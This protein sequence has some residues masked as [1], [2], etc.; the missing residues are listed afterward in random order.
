MASCPGRPSAG[1]QG[2]TITPSLEYIF[3][4]L[5]YV[6][7]IDLHTHRMSCMAPF[8][9][10]SQLTFQRSCTISHS[11][12]TVAGAPQCLLVLVNTYYGLFCCN[13]AC[14]CGW[15]LSCSVP[16]V[17]TSNKGGDLSSIVVDSKRSKDEGPHLVIVSWYDI[18]W[19]KAGGEGPEITCKSLKFFYNKNSSFMKAGSRGLSSSH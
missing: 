8:L 11:Q 10:N 17:G 14:G 2:W 4:A 3:N 12:P 9:K 15:H 6:L 1:L 18:Q 16:G 5:G 7:R 13:Q 19:Q